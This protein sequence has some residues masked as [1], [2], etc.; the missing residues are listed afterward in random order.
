[1]AYNT[2]GSVM[3][4]IP[5]CWPNSIPA[6]FAPRICNV[7]TCRG[8]ALRISQP[9]SHLSSRR[10]A[11]GIQGIPTMLKI[12]GFLS[13]L[14]PQKKW[15][16]ILGNHKT[17]RKI[18]DLWDILGPITMDF[19][20]SWGSFSESID[21]LASRCL[22]PRCSM[23]PDINSTMTMGNKMYSTIGVPPNHPFYWD[24]PLQNIHLGVPH[25]LNPPYLQ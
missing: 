16:K 12:D 6:N 9:F 24:F 11:V 8:S 22:D 3:G 23:R 10:C 14:P 25:I 1:M 17:L 4:F 13:H 20:V 21:S 18:T 5:L 19:S 2:Y 15:K 7:A